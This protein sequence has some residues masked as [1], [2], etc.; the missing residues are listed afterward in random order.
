MH[1]EKIYG[2]GNAY[3]REA[4]EH[5]QRDGTEWAPPD[6]GIVV[7]G[8]PIGS[9]VFER[10]IVQDK[11]DIIKKQLVQLAELLSATVT[12]QKAKTQWAYHLVRLCMPSQLNYLLRTVHPSRTKSPAED[13]DRHIVEFLRS[14][15]ASRRR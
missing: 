6:E 8:T 11:V 5:A 2:F 1:K 7:V 9:E 15:R 4:Q 12:Y 10:R 14:L 3:S 13:L